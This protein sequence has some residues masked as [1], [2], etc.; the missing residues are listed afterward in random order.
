MTQRR[1]GRQEVRREQRPSF[2]AR[3]LQLRLFR[4]PYEAYYELRYKVTWPTFEEA[5]NMTIAVIALS[6][7]LGIVLG[8]VDIGL[9]QLFRLITGTAR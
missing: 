3:L 9:F 8:L 1:E 6:V 7:A 4:F 2:F 5:R